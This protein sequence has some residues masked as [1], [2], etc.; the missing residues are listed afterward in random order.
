MLMLHKRHKK[1]SFLEIMYACRM[2]VLSL[3]ADKKKDLSQDFYFLF[4]GQLSII[5][6]IHIIITV[7][8]KTGLYPEEINQIFEPYQKIKLKTAIEK[9]IHETST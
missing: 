1:N 7:W 3:T 9:K 5:A 4:P 2:V 8:L 6:T